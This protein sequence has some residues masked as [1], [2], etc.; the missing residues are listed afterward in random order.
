[1]EIPVIYYESP[2]RVLKNLEML[3]KFSVDKKIIVG[4]ELTK[5]FEEV[6]RGSIEEILAYFES[7]PTKVKGEFVIIVH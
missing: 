7:N 6:V 3:A 4:R 2:H 5:M 1:M